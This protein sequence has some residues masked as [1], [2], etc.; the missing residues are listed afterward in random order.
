MKQRLRNIRL[1]AWTLML[2]AYRRRE[3]YAIVFVTT[4]LI[5]GLRMIRFFEMEDLGKFYREI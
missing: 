4:V 5:V 1:I 2:E 3:I